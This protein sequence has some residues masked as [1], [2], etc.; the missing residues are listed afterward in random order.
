MNRLLVIGVAAIAGAAIWRRREI[1]SDAERAS[2]AIADATNSARSR[3]RSGNDDESDE[4]AEDTADA[5]VADDA[6]DADDA[7]AAAASTN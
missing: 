1:R 7:A 4:A 6:D 5:E 3:I 2:K